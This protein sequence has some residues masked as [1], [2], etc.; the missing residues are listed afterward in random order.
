MPAPTELITLPDAVVADLRA[1][2]GEEAIR[3]LQARLCAATPAV[4]SPPEL[5]AALLD[6]ARLSSVCI[7]PEIALPHART[8]AVERVVLAVARA[9]AGIAFDAEHP[10]VRLVFLI[11]TPRQAVA[12]YLQMVAT[13]SRWLRTAGVR[14]ALLAAPGE[15]ELRGILARATEKKP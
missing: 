11:G 2:S 4:K 12:E 6:R 8:D 5:L 15:K 7:A 10:A 1:A 14:E 9:P 3:L 13:L